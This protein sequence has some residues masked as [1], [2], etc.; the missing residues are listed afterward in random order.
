MATDK[1]LINTEIREKAVNLQESPPRLPEIQERTSNME[2]HFQWIKE[3]QED[4]T[5]SSLKEMT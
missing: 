3:F 2:H 5:Y 1:V 4:T